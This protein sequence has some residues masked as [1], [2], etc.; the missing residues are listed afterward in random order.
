MKRDVLFDP[1]TSVLILFYVKVSILGA[2]NIL[3]NFIRRVATYKVS[4]HF[5]TR[6][7]WSEWERS[8]YEEAG[9]VDPRLSG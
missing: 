7:L 2:A 4:V 3:S 1:G 5:N 9:G 6:M 8:S